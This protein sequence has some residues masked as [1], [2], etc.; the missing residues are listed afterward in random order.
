MYLEDNSINNRR[1]QS[2]NTKLSSPFQKSLPTQSG[3]YISTNK[4][5]NEHPQ[6]RLNR[7]IRAR[8][9]QLS[10]SCRPPISSTIGEPYLQSSKVVVATVKDTAQIMRM[11][12]WCLDEDVTDGVSGPIKTLW[13]CRAGYD[14]AAVKSIK[15]N[16]NKNKKNSLKKKE[17]YKKVKRTYFS[18]FQD[19]LVFR[20][21][22]K[23]KKITIHRINCQPKWLSR[24]C[25]SA[26]LIIIIISVCK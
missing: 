6:R 14:E 2:N 8:A 10:S 11:R 20:L 1:T 23:W 26:S 12:H 13:M 18:Q 25:K 9:I 19:N 15:Q 4:A 3:P 24:Y 16:Q 7:M 22:N 21:Y 5:Q 17:N